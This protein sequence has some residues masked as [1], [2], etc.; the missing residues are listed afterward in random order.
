VC[1]KTGREILFPLYHYST[2]LPTYMEYRNYFD[3]REGDE[4]KLRKMHVAVHWQSCPYLSKMISKVKDEEDRLYAPRIGQKPR[5]SFEFR[6][7][8]CQ[9]SG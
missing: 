9:G 8:E 1:R 2:N 4:T 5:A 7:G 3:C 6:R